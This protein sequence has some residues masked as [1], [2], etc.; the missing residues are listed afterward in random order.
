MLGISRAVLAKPDELSADE[1]ARIREHPEA[2]FE[3]LRTLGPEYEWVANV[4][5][6]E[7]EREDGSGYPKG[8]K[9]DEIHEYAKIIGLADE[10]EALTHPRPYRK[11]RR[12]PS[13]AVKELITEE[14]RR[15]PDRIL[16]GLICGLSTAPV[17]SLVRLNTNET[18]RVVATNRRF[19]L[20][21]VVEIILDV[22]GEPVQP[23]R[24]IDLTTNT[25]LYITDPSATSPKA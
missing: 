12:F 3:V 5:L 7:H 4:A 23:P 9:G 24:R 6:Q 2:G 20:R 1:R 13:E 25:L 16:K 19:P 22:A 10:F 11:R 14:R 15:F 21:P 8:L 18:A 17:G